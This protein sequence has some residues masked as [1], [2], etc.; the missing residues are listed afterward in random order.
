MSVTHN[1]CVHGCN[2][3][4]DEIHVFF[5]CEVARQIW[6]ASPWGLRWEALRLNDLMSFLHCLFNPTDLI[7]IHEDDKETFLFFG[8]TMLEYLW[9]IRNT[10]YHAIESPYVQLTPDLIRKKVNEMID[11]TKRDASASH[12]PEVSDRHIRLSWRKPTAGFIKVNSYATMRSNGC[13]LAIIARNEEGKVLSIHSFKSKVSIPEVAEL[14][15]I[16][17]AMHRAQVH[18]WTKMIFETDAQTVI[19]ALH[20]KDRSLIQWASESLF[21]NI[22]LN[23]SSFQIVKFSWAPRIANNLA[24]NVSKWSATYY[25]VGPIDLIWLP[26]VCTETVIQKSAPE[27]APWIQL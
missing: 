3:S 25:V 19:K 20:M 11:A 4:E 12:S 8:A 7:P 14:E 6:L 9:K 23:I 22:M 13:F 26:S 16:A 15:A 5:L 17:K 1:E 18:G 27:E 10:S 24:H 2:Y 21:S